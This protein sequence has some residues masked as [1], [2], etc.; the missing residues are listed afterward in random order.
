MQETNLLK[1]QLL[2]LKSSQ[3]KHKK[4]IK[5][6]YVIKESDSET[7]S[8]GENETPP[9]EEEK[10]E[11]RIDEVDQYLKIKKIKKTKEKTKTI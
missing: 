7:D 6:K 2:D 3:T 9:E 8:H 1:Q 5:R 11:D 10:Q 4:T